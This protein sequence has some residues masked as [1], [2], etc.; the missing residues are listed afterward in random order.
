MHNDRSN[1]ALIVTVF[2]RSLT[3]V[4]MHTSWLEVVGRF[5]RDRENFPGFYHKKSPIDLRCRVERYSTRRC[6][7]PVV[8]PERLLRGLPQN[9]ETMLPG[10]AAAVCVL[11]VGYPNF[12]RAH[13]YFVGEIS[14]RPRARRR[15]LAGTHDGRV[16][17]VGTW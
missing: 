1:D 8:F 14:A 5:F 12:K 13:S 10:F 2:A 15:R 6:S 3:A 16:T 17:V 9:F 11:L 4:A 7:Y